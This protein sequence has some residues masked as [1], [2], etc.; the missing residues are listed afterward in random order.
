MAAEDPRAPRRNRN[1]PHPGGPARAAAEPGT[2]Q[3]GSP[4]H[5][6]GPPTT[7]VTWSQRQR[8]PGGPAHAQQNLFSK[9]NVAVC[10]SSGTPPEN[11]S[12]PRLLPVRS[13]NEIFIG[14]S[15]SSRCVPR[16]GPQSVAVASWEP[17]GASDQPTALQPQRGCSSSIFCLRDSSRPS[18]APLQGPVRSPCSSLV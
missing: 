17:R 5:H 3:S 4:H 1:Q 14:E 15:L 11:F 10:R 18:S 6:P 7:Y 13:L 9:S 2:A 16:S 8:R 12:E